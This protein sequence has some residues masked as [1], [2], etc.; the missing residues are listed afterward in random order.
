M[1]QHVSPSTHAPSVRF[2]SD[3]PT[4]SAV[5]IRRS[6]VPPPTEHLGS[7][8]LTTQ[9]AQTPRR[10]VGMARD[11]THSKRKKLASARKLVGPSMEVVAYGSG[12]GHTRGTKT[13]LCL[14]IAYVVAFIAVQIVLGRFLIPGV[15]L[16]LVV[17]YLI[18]P[19]RGIAITPFG[20]L[21]M[22][23]SMA[24]GQPTQVLFVAPRDALGAFDE[25]L[26]GRGHVRV[27]IGPELI[28]VKRDVYESLVLAIQNL[29]AVSG[30]SG[31]PSAAALP[32]P[33]WFADPLSR[34]QYRYWDGQ[35]WTEQVSQNGV[36]YSDFVD[37]T[38]SNQSAG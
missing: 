23:E 12:K 2:S 34:F 25:H 6:Y 31:A 16:I 14:G 7:R 32:P 24:N 36:V 19:L 28:R 1:F 10:S 26:E 13:L 27:Q 4:Y 9:A 33:G 5:S 17:Y 35:R 15:L 29:P 30:P 3:H 22:H 21:V 8:D 38:A 20:V 37:S 11:W 18:R